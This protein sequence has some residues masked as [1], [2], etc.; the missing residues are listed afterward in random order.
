MPT[1]AMPISNLG[2]PEG[3][4]TPDLFLE[5]DEVERS[6]LANYSSTK[7]IPGSNENARQISGKYEEAGSR[8]SRSRVGVRLAEV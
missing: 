2:S 6:G 8:S 3:I 7:L 1:S 4:R 5:R